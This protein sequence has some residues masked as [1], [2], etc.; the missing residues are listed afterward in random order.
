MCSLAA[1]IDTEVQVVAANY[2]V[3]CWGNIVFDVKGVLN[4]VKK[5]KMKLRV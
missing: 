4:A 2:D 3:Y 5:S 1:V